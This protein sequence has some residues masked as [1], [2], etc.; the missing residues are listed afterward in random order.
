MSAIETIGPYQVVRKLGEGG[1]GVVFAA[2]DA[3]LDRLVAVK[4]LR[5]GIANEEA[6][7]R[8]WR[9][10]RAAAGVSHP[11]IC[12]VFEVGEAD[13]RLYLVMELLEGEP[14]GERLRRGP[15]PE[16]EAVSILLGVLS[17]LDAV[18]RRELV[19]RDLKPSNVFLT[20][21][22]PKVLDFGLA[23]F[24]Q[25]GSEPSLLKNLT[26]PGSVLGTPRYMSPE[27][28]QGLPVESPSDI[29]A[30]GVLFYEMLTGKPA[31]TG[32]TVMAIF[33]AVLYDPPPPLPSHP[34][35]EGVLRRSL[36]R[37]PGS[38]YPS[39]AAMAEA[40][41]T[42]V[43]D[44]SSSRTVESPAAPRQTRLI[45]LPFRM[46]RP[47]PETEFLAFSLP[48]AITASL[49]GLQSLVVRSSMVAARFTG[50]APD[51]REVAE[52]A[53]V[54]AV[55]TGTLLRA[56]PQIRV[57]VQLVEAP[58]G[59]LLWSQTSQAALEDIF[60]LQD[61]L[62]K[63]I[64]ESLRQSHSSR[65][66]Q[67]L[68]RDVPVNAA[69]YEFYLRANQHAKEPEGLP[70]ARELY[71]RCLDL[72]PNY[73]PAWARL[74]RCLWL[75]AKWSPDSGIDAS[76]AENA[77]ERAFSINPDLAIAHQLYGRFETDRGRARQSMVRLLHRASR[78]RQDAELF[79]GLVHCCRYC[80]L[81]DAS[82]AAF[83][84]A[85]ALDPQI[86]TSVEHTYF[87]RGDHQKVIELSHANF[88]FV[89]AQSLMLLGRA[90]EADE[91]ARTSESTLPTPMLRLY[92]AAVRAGLG[93]NVEA[94]RHAVGEILSLKLMDLEGLHYLS[95]M[96]VRAGLPDEAVQLARRSVSGGWWCPQPMRQDLWLEPLRARDDY[97]E[98]IA[99]A[100]KGRAESLA[101]YREADGP[102]LLGADG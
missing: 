27:Q 40:L 43:S 11:N 48:D 54:D 67:V 65:E 80:G 97:R 87:M 33:H 35:I 28:L 53:Q 9:E 78:F 18:H 44:S 17:A 85:R 62:A 7:L 4:M 37:D 82:V 69:A 58:A 8:F 13:G 74:G 25:A 95:R 38:R 45:V 30:A 98:L 26:Q 51:L 76:Q 81:L 70:V 36:A 34:H 3:R 52:Q 92:L 10:A 68:R 47:D 42:M 2:R 5:E 19:H 23:R 77:F 91:L 86:Q 71:Q 6:R 79:A 83:E 12:Q 22:G 61:G 101:A 50:P 60:E 89:V 32:D 56:G 21:H 94:L 88:G 41:R 100:E 14:L 59:T 93:E 49:S 29:F 99:A 63:R 73:A 64:F 31:F 1:M 75:M 72:D 66:E 20:R 46:L 24:T 55:L 16:R 57:S 84:R 102:D 96:T 15:L 90:R 39:A